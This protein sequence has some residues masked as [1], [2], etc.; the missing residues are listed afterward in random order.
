MHAIRDSKFIG[1]RIRQ[2][3]ERAGLSQNEVGALL[4]VSYQQVQKYE[5]GINSVS[6]EKLQRLAQALRVPM[7]A[8]FAD[9]PPPLPEQA[10]ESAFQYQPASLSRRERDL[11][12][13][14]RAIQDEE[15][16]GCLVTLIKLAAQMRRQR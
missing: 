9:V 2:L 11:L 1:Q 15:L 10:G 7:S 8:F 16:S 6:V 13:W 14:F 3:R 4:D 12:G 5:R